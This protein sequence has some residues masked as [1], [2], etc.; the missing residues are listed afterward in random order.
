M[1]IITSL[2]R[3]AA[4]KDLTLE[5]GDLIAESR[6]WYSDRYQTAVVQRNILL[7]ITILAIVCIL[8]GVFVVGEISLSKSVDPFVIE[9]EEKSGITNIVTPMESKTLT[10]DESIKRYF[11]IKYLRA[12]ETYDAVD[13]EFNYSTLVRLFSTYP[14]Y[15]KFKSFTNDDPRSPIKVYGTLGKTSLKI[16]SIQ[17]FEEGKAQVRFTIIE[18]GL[19]NASHN[20]IATLKFQ[21]QKMEL[22]PADLEINPLGFQI[23]EYRVDDETL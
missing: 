10:A 23:I 20:K 7:I 14:I 4:E 1:G 22:S 3:R 15:N 16:R 2:F 13:Y 11:I 18:N 19:S 5:S 21:Y 6:N 17:F 9:V 8:I 12:R